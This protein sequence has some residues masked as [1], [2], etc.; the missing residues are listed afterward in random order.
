MRRT[1]VAG[2]YAKAILGLARER[3]QLDAVTEDFETIRRAIIAS[4]DLENLLVTPTVDHGLKDRI[5]RQIFD[6]KISDLT[7]LFIALLTRKGRSAD[8]F[9]IS[10]AFRAQL[11][12]AN[13]VMPA[14][15]TTAVELPA[16]QLERIRH[17]LDA[18]SGMHIRAEYRTDPTLVGG[19]RARFGDRL[20]DASVRHQLEKLHEVLASG[21]DVGTVG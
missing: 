1:R 12:A 6:G 11:D 16:D 3:Q 17:R 19:F 10:D 2:R 15:V 18:I 7:M 20:V 21:G 13:G 8:L 9:A 14:V 4:R 5:L